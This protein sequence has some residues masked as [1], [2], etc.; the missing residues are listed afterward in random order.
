MTNTRQTTKSHNHE[1]G[2]T[3]TMYQDLVSGHID[4][5]LREGDALRAER[6][7]ANLRHAASRSAPDHRTPFRP[8]RV[9][10]GRWLVAAG[11]AVAGGAAEPHGTT[12]RAA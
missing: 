8:I 12:R 9:R 4:D 2:D 1:L 11:W 5:L 6:K 7:E 10:L 3:S